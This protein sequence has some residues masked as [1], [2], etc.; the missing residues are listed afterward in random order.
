MA[1]FISFQ[2]SDYYNTK[3]YTGNGTAIGSGGNALTGVGFQPDFTWIKCRDATQGHQ[4]FDSVRGATEVIWPDD[5][6]AETTRT[7]S[8]ASW[9]SD[10]F[11]LG[12]DGDVNTNTDTYASWNFK[13]GTTTGIDTTGSDITPTSYSFNQA[14]GQSII[15]YPG[16][17]SDHWLPH[18]LGKVPQLVMIKAT[19]AVKYWMCYSAV[20]G[21]A[22]EFYL[23]QSSTAGAS[24]T[25]NSTTPTSVNISLDPGAGNGVNASGTNYVGYFF[26]SIRGYSQVNQYRGNGNADGTCVYTGF[27]PAFLLVKC[28]SHSEPWLLWD[29]KRLGYNVENWRL[30]PNQNV[31]ENQSE[32]IDLLSNGFKLRTSGA[33]MNGSARQYLYYACAEFPFVSSNS[34]SGVAR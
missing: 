11:T 23:N 17:G 13:M 30:M 27:R 25:W 34:K 15:L 12:N 29:D 21:N 28:V 8:L 2:P 9:Q 22:K 33:H 26:T 4:L 6:G 10:G 14:T 5:A 3:L 16:S 32:E 7:E 1:A 31:V 18:G 20:T 24:T 19:D